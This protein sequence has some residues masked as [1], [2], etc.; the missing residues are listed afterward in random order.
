MN[1]NKEM[2]V[3]KLNNVLATFSVPT[4][5]RNN[6]AWLLNNLHVGNTGHRNLAEAKNL[7]VQII[8]MNNET[9]KKFQ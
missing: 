1:E 4:D 8:D 9:R 6:H 7:L 5:K 2:L 3:K